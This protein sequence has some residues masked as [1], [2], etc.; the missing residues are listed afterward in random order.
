MLRSNGAFSS[1]AAADLRSAQRHVLHPQVDVSVRHRMIH[2]GGADVS[3]ENP[4][5]PANASGIDP[6]GVAGLHEF[7]ILQVAVNQPDGGTRA[8]RHRPSRTQFPV[9]QRAQPEHIQ[10]RIKRSGAGDRPR[11]RVTDRR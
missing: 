6:A 7:I 1:S 11:A 4:V 3:A 5:A 8:R 2:H 10:G 9:N